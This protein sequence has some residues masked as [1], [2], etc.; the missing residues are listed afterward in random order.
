[1]ESP[2]R[3]AMAAESRKSE[4]VTCTVT[5]H[6]KQRVVAAAAREGHTVGSFTRRAL[7]LV[8]DGY[9]DAGSAGSSR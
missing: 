6:M 9:G 7:Q 1:M 2:G 3:K 4:S 5:P 8:L